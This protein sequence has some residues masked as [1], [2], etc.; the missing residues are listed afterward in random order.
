MAKN[1]IFQRRVDGALKTFYPKTATDNVVRK[2]DNGEKSLDTIL[3]NK[4]AFIQYTEDIV[5]NSGKNDL[6]L[7]VL[8]D[9]VNGETIKDTK[10]T[11]ISNQAPEDTG[12]LWIDKS[13]KRSVLKYY[14]ADAGRWKPVTIGNSTGMELFVD[15][16]GILNISYDDG[17]DE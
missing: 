8:G 4:G 3:D 11:I 13:G 15:D 5:D 14:D 10:G 16:N 1:V 12:Y 7:E 6:L 9:V 17:E 2:T